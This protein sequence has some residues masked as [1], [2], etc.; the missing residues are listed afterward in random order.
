[1]EDCI[2]CKIVKG[3]IPSEKIYEDEKVL[4]ILDIAPLNKGHVLVIPKEHVRWVHELNLD[5]NIWN[6]AH[7]IGKSIVSNLQYNHINFLTLGYEVK[8]GHIHVIPR[9]L[10]DDLGNHVDWE[11]RKK[12]DAN[13]IGKFADKIK[14]GL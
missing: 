5:T 3:D 6:V 1:M 13:E 9:N 11:K 12:Y 14:L 4:A 8:H 2:F 7:K 10:D